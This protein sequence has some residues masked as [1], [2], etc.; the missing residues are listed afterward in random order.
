[1]MLPALQAEEFVQLSAGEGLA[2]IVRRCARSLPGRTLC[3]VVVGL[4]AHLELRQSREWRASG[5]SV[6]IGHAWRWCGP[7]TMVIYH[8][9]AWSC[10]RLVVA[11]SACCS[12]SAAPQMPRTDPLKLPT[13]AGPAGEGFTAQ[14][15][16]SAVAA[17]ALRWPGVRLRYLAD[18]D[19]AADHLIQLTRALAEQP[20]VKQA[21]SPPD[22]T[23]AF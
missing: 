12:H 1:M 18:A 4:D 14:R 23:G 20:H 8:Q 5:A 17:L 19:A 22:K 10:T 6:Q 9:C 13:A 15:T 21:R 16:R 7:R 3:L 11:A 2:N